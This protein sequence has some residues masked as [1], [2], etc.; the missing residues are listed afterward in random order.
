MSMERLDQVAKLLDY[1]SKIYL[2]LMRNTFLI[3]CIIKKAINLIT[4]GPNH[5][6][7]PKQLQ[8]LY[9]DKIKLLEEKCELLQKENERLVQVNK[10]QTF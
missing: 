5:F 2:P 3:F 4:L 8:K 10:K 1:L 9:E 7:F 6:Y